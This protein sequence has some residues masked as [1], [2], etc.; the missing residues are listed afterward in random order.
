MTGRWQL[1][2]GGDARLPFPV[3]CQARKVFCAPVSVSWFTSRRSTSQECLFCSFHPSPQ[4]QVDH[5]GNWRRS[6]ETT[7]LP[8]SLSVL[9]RAQP[10]LIHPSCATGQV[11]EGAVCRLSYCTV[12][13]RPVFSF[14]H[15]EVFPPMGKTSTTLLSLRGCLMSTATQPGNLEPSIS[16]SGAVTGS[17][18]SH[19]PFTTAELRAIHVRISPW[20]P[21]HTACLA[22]TPV[23][24]AKAELS[25]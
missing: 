3:H 19:I 17:Y 8:K 7:R 18:V 10:S 9:N 2:E 6:V 23:P 15:C 20:L 16:A 25:Q 13:P 5:D 4:A 24:L 11:F 21:G 22:W 1:R 14:R 12:R